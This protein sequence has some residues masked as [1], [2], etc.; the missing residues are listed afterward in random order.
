MSIFSQCKESRR[1][2]HLHNSD[3]VVCVYPGFET[4]RR[5]DLFKNSEKIYSFEEIIRSWVKPKRLLLQMPENSINVIMSALNTSKYAEYVEQVNHV[6]VNVMTQNIE[7]IKP[8]PEFANLFL[9]SP[10]VTQTTAHKKYATQELS[11]NYHTPVHHLSVFND[12]SQYDVVPFENKEDLIVYSPDHHPLKEKIIEKIESSEKYKTQ[13]I[14]GL[15]YDKYKKLVGRAKFCLTFGEGFDGYFIESYFSGSIGLS[16]YNDRFFPEES[17]K[18]LPSVS[19]SYESM[20]KSL[21]QTLALLDNPKAYNECVADA[22][23]K[24]DRANNEVDYLKKME[25]FYKKD[26]DY[27]PEPI[28]SAEI[29][30]C[31]VREKREK[32][33]LADELQAKIVEL[34]RSLQK[35]RECSQKNKSMLDSILNSRSWRVTVPLRY[36]NKSTHRQ[37]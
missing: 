32:S 29:I 31:V 35:E 11:N 15:T 33:E 10:Y 6:H 2:S 34:S 1:F 9:L 20:L 17:F 8:V 7:L 36:L 5:N 4:Y 28:E 26:Y 27:L 12:K 24:I 3:V 25:R 30:S 16:V 14:R 18:K 22:L 19:D 37:K 23:E 13:E 21:D